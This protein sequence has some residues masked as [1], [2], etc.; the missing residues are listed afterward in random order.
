MIF[1]FYLS[2]FTYFQIQ[3]NAIFVRNFDIDYSGGSET[4]TKTTITSTTTK[5]QI[6]EGNSIRL[7]THTVHKIL[8]RTEYEEE[9]EEVSDYSE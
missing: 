5:N 8:T 4:T 9:E 3:K 2:T 6:Q 7:E 1:H